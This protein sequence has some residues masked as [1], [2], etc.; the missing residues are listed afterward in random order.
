MTRKLKT[1]FNTTPYYDDFSKDK[2]FLKVL[3]KPSIAVQT[4]ELNQIQSLITEQISRF[5]DYVFKDGS[6]VIDGS[7]NVNVNVSYIKLHQ[8]ELINDSTLSVNTY[9]EQ[10]EGRTLT[11][12]NG[13]KFKV[14]KVE[15]NNTTEPNTLIGDYLSG[16]IVVQAGEVLTTESSDSQTYQVTVA[17]PE[18]TDSVPTGA[19][20]TGKSSL[21]SVDDGIFYIAGYF[22][23]TSKQIIVLDKYSNTPSYRIGLELDES[24]ITSGDD[25][26]LY[27][28]AQGSPNYSAP[29]ADRYKISLILTK[30]E[31]LESD[32]NSIDSVLNNSSFDFFEFVRIRNGEKVDQIKNSQYSYIGEELARRTYDTNGDFVVNNFVLDIDQHPTDNEK[33]LLTLD[34]GKAYVKGYEIETIFPTEIDLKKGRQSLSK[35][36]ENNPSFIGNNIKVLVEESS[37]DTHF[38]QLFDGHSKL[39]IYDSTDNEIGTCRV[40]QFINSDSDFKGEFILSILDLQLGD[41][42]NVSDIVYFKKG[43]DLLFKVSGNSRSG[44]STDSSVQYVSGAGPTIISEPEKSPL[45]FGV[46]ESSLKS[47]DRVHFFSNKY[48]EAVK[49][50]SVNS[51]SDGTYVVYKFDLSSNEE[52][53]I[54]N[55]IDNFTDWNNYFTDKEKIRDNVIIY[56]G[57]EF[58]DPEELESDNSSKYD[59]G[60]A[61]NSDGSQIKL[62]IKTQVDLSTDPDQLKVLF[63]TQIQSITQ[64]PSTKKIKQ[65]VTSNNQVVTLSSVPSDDID[66]VIHAHWKMNGI[67]C[68]KNTD[69]YQLTKV[70][71]SDVNEGNNGDVTSLFELD[72]GQEDDFYNH[73]VL[74]LKSGSQKPNGDLTIEYQYFDHSAENHGYFILSSYNTDPSSN[75]SITYEEIPQFIS[76]NTGKSYRLADY[77]DFR[78][79][80]S[81]KENYVY[82]HSTD[83]NTLTVNDVLASDFPKLSDLFEDDISGSNI[84]YGED[85]DYIETSYEYYLSRIDKLV[86]TK[87]KQFRII[88]GTPSEFPRTP[89]DDQDSMSLY[90]ITVPP[91]TYNNNDVKS[92]PVHNRRYTM[93]DIGILDRRIEELQA[94]SN[95]RLLQEKSK[96]IQIRDAS[97]NDI[98]KN[99]VL[100]DDFSGHNI[101]KVIDQDYKCSIDFETKELRPSFRSDSH[102]VEFDPTNSQNIVKKGPIVLSSY[103]EVEHQIQPLSTK[104]RNLNPH[105]MPYWFGDI[106]MNPSSDMWFNKSLDPKVNVNEFG[107]NDAWIKLNSSVQNDYGKGFGTQ[108]NDWETLWTGR[109]SFFATDEVNLDNLKISSVE[110]LE[111]DTTKNYLFDVVDRIG[112]VNTG[113]SNRIEKTMK[114]KK[115][116]NSVVPYMRSVE[117]DFIAT[118]LNPQTTFYPFLDNTPV[119]S[120][121]TPCDIITISDTNVEFNDGI[122]D[123]E[124]LTSLGSSGASAKVI[125]N[126]EDGS[127]KIYVK[128]IQGTFLPNETIVGSVSGLSSTIVEHSTQSELISDEHGQLC[129]VLNI[130]SDDVKFRTGQRLFRLIN[131]STNNLTPPLDSENNKPLMSLCEN[132]FSSQGIM[133]DPENFVSSTRIPLK[134]RSNICDILSLARDPY[135]REQ[136]VLSR[137]LD[138]RD[139]LSQTFVVDMASNRNGIFL[140]SVDLFFKSKDDQLPV[141]IEIRPTSNGMPSTSTVIPFSEVILNS[142]KVKVSEG[143]KPDDVTSNTRFTFDSPIHL[144]PGEYALV[145]KTNS[146]EYEI[147]SGQNGVP[148]LDTDGST[149]INNTTT[150]RLPLIGRLYS[151]YN[152]GVWEPVLDENLMFRLNKCKF[153]TSLTKKLRLKVKPE[154]SQSTYDFSLFKFNVS[155]LKNFFNTQNPS[156]NCTITANPP[157]QINFHENR[158]TELNVVRSF[159]GDDDFYIE[160][161]FEVSDPD[162]SPVIDLERT[163]LITVDNIV[164]SYDNVD[165]NWKSDCVYI[166]KRVNLKYPYESKDIKVYLDAYVPTTT[167]KILVYYKVANSNGDKSF[168]DSE[169]YLMEQKTPQHIISEYNND[170]REFVFGTN[171]GVEPVKGQTPEIDNF[172]IYAIKIEITS[173]DKSKTPKV[174]NL[175]AIALQEPAG[176]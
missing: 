97:G 129:G 80:I 51:N 150:T 76:K 117:V 58:Y 24:L 143:P 116:D 75:S 64:N 160:T 77:I 69:I 25:I 104:H 30:K 39:D 36:L 62:R 61:Q 112:T 171:G 102:G 145:V 152:S 23:K 175:R 78:S 126:K 151:S 74:T 68:L 22:H 57:S 106:K 71:S 5:G 41:N 111:D 164:N 98:F 172:N 166:S 174:R 83:L 87:D 96:N 146:S 10:L 108:W 154:D 54:G 43:S 155:M 165:P 120:N 13:V 176:V 52:S 105:E 48:V 136:N 157:V 60:I 1:E 156:F 89:P 14:R 168:N 63:R 127:G 56:N 167:S 44:A 42:K 124:V 6:P 148:V 81:I 103:E 134:K 170:Y 144:R 114:N 109:E 141:S 20:I 59:I 158:N 92:V 84:P 32:D 82:S 50:S 3:F 16:D 79:S 18:L 8:F 132:T 65:L 91:Y 125:K 161:N 94:R 101:G 123:G 35:D 4:R 37:L 33:L 138:W 27:D 149:D 99:G 49:D 55:K 90:I 110:K 95:L 15:A 139:P 118:N 2:N 147:W 153:D 21:V 169:W 85:G 137:C 128:P 12:S 46:E 130:P 66:K 159:S 29:G 122:Y 17:T 38:Q 131:N 9:I 163:S 135:T 73:G 28:N 162:V 113:L 93:R 67:I 140:S 31:L 72:N 40:K 100:I 107:E 115:V 34:P 11:S 88:E 86:L 26:S 19:S 121:V 45:L 133:E 53:L 7:F 119:S 47:V 142:S 70:T 173:D